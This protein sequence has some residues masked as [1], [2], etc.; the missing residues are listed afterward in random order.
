MIVSA[1]LSAKFATGSKMVISSMVRSQGLKTRVENG[2]Y[3]LPITTR[4]PEMDMVS[5]LIPMR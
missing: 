3:T 4:L 1:L 2:A 5:M